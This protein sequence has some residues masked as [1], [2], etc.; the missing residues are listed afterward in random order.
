M[1][2]DQIANTAEFFSFGTNDLTQTTL[3]MSR[4]DYG[5]FIGYYQEN[6]IIPND[7][8]Q[9][10]DQ[11][12]VGRLMEQG[13]S[14][15]RG[16]RPEL[17]IRPVASMV[18][19]RLCHVTAPGSIMSLFS[20][21]SDRPSSPPPRPPC[22]KRKRS[23]FRTK[24]RDKREAINLPLT[25]NTSAA[26]F[27]PWEGAVFLLIPFVRLPCATACSSQCHCACN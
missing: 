25:E 4:D 13:V 14:L 3:G 2:A 16:T 15:G 12:G 22:W 20:F 21:H 6:D 18:V 19:T 11:T 1:T 24:G 7:P 23:K 5:G 9:T 8:F 10:I 17:K 27:P 26:F